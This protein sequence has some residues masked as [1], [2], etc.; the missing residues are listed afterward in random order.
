[1]AA[2]SELYAGLYTQAEPQRGE[3]KPRRSRKK[4]KVSGSG[5]SG[6]VGK[7]RKLRA[8]QAM[9]LEQSFGFEHKLAS[10]R[11]DRL[12][13]E[14]GLEPR[15][16]AVWFQNRRARWKSSK[17]GEEYS[18]LRAQHDS[19]VLEKCRLEAEVSKMKDQLNDAQK[20]IQRLSERFDNFSSSS[21]NSSL[22][23]HAMDSQLLG[24]FAP[25]NFESLFYTMD[26]SYISSIESTN[27]Y[28]L[29]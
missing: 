22:T 8:E 1:M 3:W 16:V 27:I 9:L 18:K 19:A 6:G 11:K 23:M 28:N 10:E 21:Q 5:S 29:E 24:E 15:Q 4:N 12:A 13:M 26:N 7:K 14:L 2:N 25:E 20:E 17:L